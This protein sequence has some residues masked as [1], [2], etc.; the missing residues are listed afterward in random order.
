MRR[1]VLAAMLAAMA[2]PASAV[3][4]PVAEPT[5]Q[6]PPSP[7]GLFGFDGAG[8]YRLYEDWLVVC[9]NVASCVAL[10]VVPDGSANLRIARSG[11]WAAAPDLVAD[12]SFV[13]F[14]G[15]AV[16][17]LLQPAARRPH[18]TPGRRA[19]TRLGMHRIAAGWFGLPDEGSASFLAAARSAES[20]Q[21]VTPDGRVLAEVSLRGLVAAMDRIDHVQTRTGTITGTYTRGEILVPLAAIMPPPAPVVEPVSGAPDPQA[22]ALGNRAFRMVCGT[23]LSRRTGDAV[24]W[25][26]ASGHRIVAVDCGVEGLNGGR[27]WLV[28]DPAGKL[29][30]ARF[31]TPDLPTTEGMSGFL[32]NGWFDHVTGTLTSL[33]LGRQASDCGSRLSWQ[34]TAEGFQLAEAYRM[35]LCTGTAQLHWPRTWTVQLA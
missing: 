26:M 2:L 13:G 16:D 21:F 5:L 15:A 8:P 22:R 32:P 17:L 27:I 24:V 7:S 11:G 4:P 28:E 20:V 9:D 1:A 30:L 31:P 19:L 29:D 10:S 6:V 14:D 18:A 23:G 35:P 3:P 33:E 12:L 34:W 25:R